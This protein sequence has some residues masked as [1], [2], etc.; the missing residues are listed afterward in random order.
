MKNFGEFGRDN[1]LG[2]GFAGSGFYFSLGLLG[3]EAE[4]LKL[5]DLLD[6][7]LVGLS[8]FLGRGLVG[9]LGFA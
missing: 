6:D 8:Q 7:T 9:G 1:G 2:A 5:L 3:G 4:L